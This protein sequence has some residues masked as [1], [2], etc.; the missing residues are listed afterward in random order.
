[1]TDAFPDYDGDEDPPLPGVLRPGLHL[2]PD[3]GCPPEFGGVPVRE[4]FDGIEA[5]RQQRAA[6]DVRE[7]LM[8]GFRPRMALVPDQVGTGFESGGPLDTAL[9][10]RD[11][12]PA[13]PSQP[14]SPAAMGPAATMSALALRPKLAA[15]VNLTVPLSTALGLADHPGVVS[16]F[17][18]V[19]PGLARQ[20]TSLAA[21]HPATRACLTIT[22]PGGQAIGHGCLPGPGTLT[23]LGTRDLTLT[24]SPLARGRCDHH[25]QES[26]YH[27][28]RKLRHLIVAR[29]GTCT[30]PGCRCPAARCDLDH[31]LPY[32]QGGRTC[33]C[34][35]APLCRHHHRCKQAD[36][37]QL[38]Q[39]SPGV[40]YWTTPAGR[41]YT[42]TPGAV[43]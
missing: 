40:M 35:L 23:H 11:S 43:P 18:P 19:D 2:G 12:T 14:A 28:S 20:L 8:A 34:D 32:D 26:G 4:L 13:A 42:T 10:G 5:A 30:A 39:P 27:P 31:T 37:W 21:V 38:D 17:G 3:G 24:I 22:G 29:N 36:G 9:L 41:R 16:G 15:L 33:E 25:N 7:S 1:V 6:A